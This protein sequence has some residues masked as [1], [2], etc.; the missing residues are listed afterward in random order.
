MPLGW[1]GGP[2]ASRRLPPA[3]AATVRNDVSP[4]PRPLGAVG[5]PNFLAAVHMWGDPC[6]GVLRVKG[7][8]GPGCQ[9]LGR[10]SATKAWGQS[11]SSMSSGPGVAPGGC[12]P[13]LGCTWGSLVE[14][15]WGHAAPE[16]WLLR[17]QPGPCSGP[18]SPGCEPSAD[19]TEAGQLL[20]GQQEL[21]P[22]RNHRSHHGRRQALPQG[23]GRCSER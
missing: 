5:R 7:V 11:P 9:A 22:H 17:L 12:E 13:K 14:W 19:E 8:A 10:S 18:G 20:S 21:V 15:P 16:P 23:L 4:M 1:P 3:A 6:S 2:E